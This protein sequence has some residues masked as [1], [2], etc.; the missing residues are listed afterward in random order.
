M[1]LQIKYYVFSSNELTKKQPE[2]KLNIDG[3]K[4]ARNGFIFSI[5]P[6]AR[7]KSAVKYIIKPIINVSDIIAIG[8]FLSL[9]LKIKMLY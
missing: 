7:T 8:N 9:F 1:F 4:P 3:P 6:K 5:E 2:K